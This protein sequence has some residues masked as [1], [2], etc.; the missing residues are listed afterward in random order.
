MPLPALEQTDHT[1]KHADILQC[2]SYHLIINTPRFQI[3][4][5]YFLIYKRIDR[6]CMIS[7]HCFE[8]NGNV[9]LRILIE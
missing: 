3:R 9:F 1:C 8:A 5:L 2:V 7:E 6:L 4:H